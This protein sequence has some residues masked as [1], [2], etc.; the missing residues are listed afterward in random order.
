MVVSLDANKEQEE[1]KEDE[2]GERQRVEMIVP[3]RSFSSVKRVP[4]VNPNYGVSFLAVDDPIQ[5]LLE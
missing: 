4:V 2:E 3:M 1:G 5:F